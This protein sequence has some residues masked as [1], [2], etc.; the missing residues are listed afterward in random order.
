MFP[1]TVRFGIAWFP[2]KALAPRVANGEHVK[3]CAVTALPAGQGLVA[4]AIA[5]VLRRETEPPPV[6][7]APAFTASDGLASMVL[8]TPAAGML[9]LTLPLVPPPNSPAP[10][11]TP[12][13]VPS[14]EEPAGKG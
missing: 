7:P 4:R 8:L 12:V 11:V 3:G 9:T 10:A 14:P 1:I 13:I 5:V 2:V 6:S